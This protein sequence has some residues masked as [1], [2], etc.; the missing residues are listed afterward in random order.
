MTDQPDDAAPPASPPPR[1]AARRK[2]WL[3][4]GISAAG[5]ALGIW[6]VM[7]L[8]PRWSGG[9]GSVVK[10]SAGEVAGRKIHATL[11]Y[12]ADDGSE[13]V[14][15]SREVPLGATPGEQARRIIEAEL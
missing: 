13:L 6:L 15:V 2:L 12:V 1:V 7:L 14:P 4:F 10:G 3:I 5:V 8:L 11:F 9:A